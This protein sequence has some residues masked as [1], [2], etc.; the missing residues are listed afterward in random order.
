[1]GQHDLVLEMEEFHVPA[2]GVIPYQ[3]VVIPGNFKEDVWVKAA[4]I[5]PSNRA[6][7]HHAS[8]FIR[9]PGT[10]WLK[11]ARP[12]VAAPMDTPST[13]DFVREAAQGGESKPVSPLLGAE[14]LVGY[15][16]GLQPFVLKDTGLLVHAG[17]D[18][19]LQLHYTPT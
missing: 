3:T 13:P 2:E 10:N 18:I 17:S 6:L 7:V 12:G 15:A 9:P 11:N 4:E 14:D 19:V 1:M 16:P 8:A 5:R